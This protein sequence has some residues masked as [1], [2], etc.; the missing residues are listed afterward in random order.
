MRLPIP[1]FLSTPWS[2]ALS[3]SLRAVDTAIYEALLAANASIW[4]N[5]TAYTVGKIVISP[6][7]GSLWVCAVAHGSALGLTPFS[8]DRAAHPTY[9]QASVT[10]P[11][12]RG[13]WVSG[14][15]YT[16]ND[17]V[18]TD[19]RYAV[20]VQS[21]VAGVSFNTDLA[22][23]RW[24]VLIDLGSG[25]TAY[26]AQAEGAIASAATTDIGSVT[27]SRIAV[28]GNAAI[29][30]LGVF[31]NTFKILRFTGT[32]TLV[33]AAALALPGGKNIQVGV[34]D[35]AFV[36]SDSVGNWRCLM[37]FRG[38]G[39]P[40]TIGAAIL[41]SAATVD[42]G[43]VLAQTITITGTTTITSLGIS[44]PLGAVKVIIAGG[45]W[46]MTH[47]AASL[48]LPGGKSISATGGDIGIF[49]YEAANTW[50]CVSW[51]AQGTLILNNGQI[52]FPATQN[53][54]SD[55]NTLD[56]YEEGTWTPVLAGSTVAGTYTYGVREGYYVK[57]GQDVFVSFTILLSA[58]AVAP[59]GAFMQINGLPFTSN[60]AFRQ[61]GQACDW[62][63]FTNAKV[64]VGM[65]IN[66]SAS[67]FYI[68]YN[69][70]AATLESILPPA[71]ITA[72]THISGSFSYRA[73]Q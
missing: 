39:T 66:G 2:A 9:W 30:S 57:K 69:N 28:T 52:T 45:N 12:N 36:A 1:D 48:L 61:G 53:P 41:A 27:A 6:E 44:A 21:H 60:A 8:A 24:V 32:P 42:V 72:A 3:D 25:V 40:L 50:R 20:C 14:A 19:T 51:L 64:R 23:G 10:I 26:N 4:T 11:Q 15:S 68:S 65:Q 55:A 17:F 63:G 62:S 7:D 47:N 46:S 35:I 31:I 59:T 22:A 18:T 37:F 54:S 70:A 58:I 38:D 56:D 16:A 43:S 5:G 33:N 29:T 34:G 73:S 71:E 13:V 67:F 49:V